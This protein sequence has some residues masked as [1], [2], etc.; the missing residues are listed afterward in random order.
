LDAT[1]DSVPITSA[2]AFVSVSS[3][4]GL[5]LLRAGLSAASISGVRRF[6]RAGGLSSL[7][8]SRSAA[9]HQHHT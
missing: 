9:K 2:S 7:L 1:I 4:A 5:N 8:L 3:V 6:C